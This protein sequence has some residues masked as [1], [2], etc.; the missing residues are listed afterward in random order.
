MAAKPQSHFSI[1]CCFIKGDQG[2]MVAKCCSRKAVRCGS[3]SYPRTRHSRP[4]EM[5]SSL[6]TWSW[7]KTG[8][9]SNSTGGCTRGRDSRFEGDYPGRGAHHTP[10]CSPPRPSWLPNLAG[11][12]ARDA[13][14]SGPFQKVGSRKFQ[15]VIVPALAWT[16]FSP[17]P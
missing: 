11:F 4:L 3:F 6:L 16:P 13:V 15:G 12:D 10:P 17:S 9:S 5:K 7:N 8:H 2:S 14:P 1:P